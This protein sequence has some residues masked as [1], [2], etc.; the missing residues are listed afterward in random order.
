MQ[1]FYRKA[2]VEIL[3]LKYSEEITERMVKEKQKIA[4]DMGKLN[5]FIRS[6]VTTNPVSELYLKKC[7]EQLM[8]MTRYKEV[9]NERIEIMSAM[10][11]AAD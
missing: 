8:I 7:K 10:R 5:S 2:D 9:L 3:N 11:L 4:Y 1:E 6:H